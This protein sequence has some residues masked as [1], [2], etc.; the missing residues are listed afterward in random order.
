MG[1]QRQGQQNVNPDPN[2]GQDAP[3]GEQV[4]QEQR[5]AEA[6]QKRVQEEQKKAQEEQKRQQGR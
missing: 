2:A 5:R 1:E 6:E 4:D 3:T